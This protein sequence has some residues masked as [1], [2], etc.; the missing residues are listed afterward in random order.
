MFH[1]IWTGPVAIVITLVVLL[2]NLTY[3]ALAGFG[4][5]II[6]VPLLT[7]AVKVL[8]SKRTKM[9]KITDQRVS[10]TQEILQGVRFVKYFGWE[11]S[12]LERLG[13]IRG[14][15]I[16]AVQFLLGLRNAIMAVSMVNTPTYHELILFADHA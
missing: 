1:I 8:A 11:S 5:L 4:L 16:R 3:S 7:W 9:N 14:R 2:I 12:F 10:L 13:E 6:S 15:E